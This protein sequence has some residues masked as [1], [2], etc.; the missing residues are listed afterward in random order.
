MLQE[1]SF[2]LLDFGGLDLIEETFDTS[3]KD[4]NLLL[5]NHGNVLLL[6]QEF[7]KFL[8]SVQELLG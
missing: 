7:S 6:F 4:A 5:S 2:E 8:T 3:V 1:E